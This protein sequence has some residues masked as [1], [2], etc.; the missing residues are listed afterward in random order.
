MLSAGH[1]AG[2]GVAGNFAHLHDRVR[3]RPAQL[4]GD[5]A[6]RI[7]TGAAGTSKWGRLSLEDADAL[8]VKHGNC[9]CFVLFSNLK[10]IEYIIYIYIHVMFKL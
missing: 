4:L 6:H 10:A 3:D 1:A 9:L 7:R 5:S 2:R 8:V